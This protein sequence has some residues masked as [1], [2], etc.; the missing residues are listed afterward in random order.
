LNTLKNDQFAAPLG[1]WQHGAGDK[2]FR[3][4]GDAINPELS[5]EEWANTVT[6]LG[7]VDTA[8]AQY[9]IKGATGS[10]D[11]QTHGIREYILSKNKGSMTPEELEA[12]DA[13]VGNFTP[14]ILVQDAIS[15]KHI[16]AEIGQQRSKLEMML[17]NVG[18]ISET[19]F[20]ENLLKNEGSLDLLSYMTLIHGKG[21]SSKESDWIRKNWEHFETLHAAQQKTETIT[22]ERGA[23]A[24][25]YIGMDPKLAS[26]T[27]ENYQNA[28]KNDTN[29][30]KPFMEEYEILGK[31]GSPLN[32]ETMA[33]AAAANAR[34]MPSKVSI[35]NKVYKGFG[36]RA[37]EGLSNMEKAFQMAHEG[38]GQRGQQA[39][40]VVT[41]N[42]GQVT[43][44]TFAALKWVKE[45]TK[46]IT[47]TQWIGAA[48]AGVVGITALNM[49]FGDG[50]PMSPN[51]LP[52]VNN[53]SFRDNR[54]NHMLENRSVNNVPN[55]NG[56]VGLI[57]DG[58]NS[59]DSTMNHLQSNFGN[60]FSSV[61]VRHDG[62]D[63]YK[64]HMMRYN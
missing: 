31:A 18:G 38:V 55:A 25:E 30:V 57:T 35:E 37:M 51:D 63:P 52:S 33:E 9:M 60:N 48:G 40:D 56:S 59:Y 47:A 28:I 43:K 61:S 5:A 34:A 32:L 14:K 6:K 11:V 10:T 39:L 53:P 8:I 62:Q 21:D 2:E 12:L 24:L 13:V 26:Q 36:G 44:R 19:A 1:S 42:T 22:S 20:R 17:D 27:M 45:V 46:N 49:L 7:E 58:Y 23:A 29:Y 3:A 64:E 50:T 54:Y 41:G 15:S 16:A 4:V